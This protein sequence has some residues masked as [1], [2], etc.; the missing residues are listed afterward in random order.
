[1]ADVRV[2]VYEDG[3][4]AVEFDH[5]CIVRDKR[6]MLNDEEFWDDVFGMPDPFAVEEP[7]MDCIGIDSPTPCPEC[8]ATGACGNDSE[9]RP[10]IHV[11]QEDDE[12]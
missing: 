6:R 8:G 11:V 1:M 9:G 12:G 4:V 3:I 10:M 7:D 2:N 5:A